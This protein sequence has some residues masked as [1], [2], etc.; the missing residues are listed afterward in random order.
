MRPEEAARVPRL[1][2][3]CVF[4]FFF[5]TRSPCGVE[6]R[7]KKR[8]IIGHIGVKLSFYMALNGLWMQNTTE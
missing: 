1:V 2:P 5:V 7:R 4:L 3:R 8:R 6:Q